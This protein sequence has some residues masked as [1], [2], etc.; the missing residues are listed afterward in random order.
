[1]AANIAAH[2]Y[3]GLRVQKLHYTCMTPF[4]QK[5]WKHH[6]RVIHILGVYLIKQVIYLL[7]PLEI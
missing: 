7:L 1:M 6:F 5:K 4:N 3:S 2:L